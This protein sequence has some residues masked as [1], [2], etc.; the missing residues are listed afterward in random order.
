MVSEVL[1]AGDIF[2]GFRIIREL[3]KG[4]MGI[5]YLAHDPEL[6]RDVALKTILASALK[7]ARD[8]ISFVTRFE[9][10]AKLAVS[11]KHKNVAQAFRFGEEGGASYLACEFIDG[12]ELSA[13][14]K[15]FGGRLEPAH[16]LSVTKDILEGLSAFEEKS[17]I[18]RDIKPDNILLTRDGEVKISDLG[19]ARRVEGTMFTV[20]GDILGTPDYMSPEQIQGSLDLDSRCDI[21]AVGAMLFHLIVG[22]PPYSAKRLT[23]LLKKHLRDRVPDI[24]AFKDG[25]PPEIGRLIQSFMAKERDDRPATIREAIK[26]V[27]ECLPLVEE[28]QSLKQTMVMLEEPMVTIPLPDGGLPLAMVED[29]TELALRPKRLETLGV[30]SECLQ[31]ARLKIIGEDGSRSDLFLYAQDKLQLG[32]NAVGQGGQDL[33]LRHRPAA[34]N[35]AKIR[36]ISGTHLGLFSSGG[37]CWIRD[38]GSSAG[39]ELNSVVLPKEKSFPLLQ[40]NEVVVAG[41][42]TLKVTAVPVFGGPLEFG[43]LGFLS[44]EPSLFIERVSNGESHS[45]G[46]V[47]GS[48]GFMFSRSGQASHTAIWPG[49]LRVFNVGGGLWVLDPQNWDACRPLSDGMRLSIGAMTVEASQLRPEHQK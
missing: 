34:G 5:V 29:V 2:A 8:P 12:G 23:A 17:W 4:A 42:L 22:K 49:D 15:R 38:L 37:R 44:A 14:M 24:C 21:Y 39:T 32:R 45:Y 27:N 47:L 40:V 48:L 28:S 19:L 36:S 33:C 43:S 20:E 11:I 41:N 6:K 7:N 30:A 3:G 16:A 26:Q 35:E 10:E 18:H 9:R 25:L 13:L 1:K 31:R 46:M